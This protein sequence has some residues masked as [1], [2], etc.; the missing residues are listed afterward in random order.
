M[1]YEELREKGNKEFNKGNFARSIDFYERAY[2]LFK[3]LE[4]EEPEHEPI[5]SA[6]QSLA[7]IESSVDLGERS[8]I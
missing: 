2:S 4:H 8:R 6:C 3:W 7:E 5:P 1:P